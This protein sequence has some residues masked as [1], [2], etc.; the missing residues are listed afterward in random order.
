MTRL[1]YVIARRINRVLVDPQ[2]SDDVPVF[3]PKLDL[4]S[5]DG[6]DHITPVYD[7]ELLSIAATAVESGKPLDHEMQLA[8]AGALRELAEATRHAGITPQPIRALNLAVHTL[9][10]KELNRGKALAALKHVALS[11][12][13]PAATVTDLI[14]T[15]RDDAPA[16]LESIIAERLAHL[17][18][19]SRADVLVAIDADMRWRTDAGVIVR[20]A[21]HP[22]KNKGISR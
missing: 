1:S 18:F 15:C 17:D 4:Y 20:P 21:S 22:P 10:A 11:W 2:G 5:I 8:V 3:W 12:S 7:A 19:A 13:I 9:V 14:A 16:M 6:L